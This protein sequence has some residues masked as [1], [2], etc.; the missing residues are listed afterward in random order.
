MAITYRLIGQFL[1][2]LIFEKMH[3]ET[4]PPLRIHLAINYGVIAAGNDPRHSFEHLLMPDC[5]EP[6]CN[7]CCCLE[8]HTNESFV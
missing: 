3:D 1:V 7:E 4:H 6:L 8:L 5:S 2:Q